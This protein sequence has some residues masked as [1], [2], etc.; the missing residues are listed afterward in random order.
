MT[1][2]Q[3]N[4]STHQTVAVPPLHCPL[5]LSFGLIFPWVG[6]GLCC[7]GDCDLMRVKHGII[8]FSIKRRDRG[9]LNLDKPSDASDVDLD[10]YWY[11]HALRP[12][13]CLC[14]SSRLFWLLLGNVCRRPRIWSGWMRRARRFSSGGVMTGTIGNQ[15]AHELMH[16]R[17]QRERFWADAL[18]AMVLFRTFRSEHWLGAP[19]LCRHPARSRNRAAL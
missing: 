4:G 5:L 10:I 19:P 16:Q 11:H 12:R 6:Y 18:L 15:H 8:E 2:P 14:S 1:S 3:P 17:K 13:G 7:G 9:G